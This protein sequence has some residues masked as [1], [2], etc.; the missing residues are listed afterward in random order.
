[1]IEAQRDELT[2]QIGTIISEAEAVRYSIE[3]WELIVNQIEGDRA[4]CHFGA[5]WISSRRVEDDPLIQ[6]MY[7]AANDLTDEAQKALA[8]ETAEGW[9][10]E[11]RYWAADE[12][13]EQPVVIM[14]EGRDLAL[15]YPYVMDGVE[16]LIPLQEFVS[17]N[18]TEDAQARYRDGIGIIQEAVGIVPLNVPEANTP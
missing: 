14:R 18:W 4:D 9:V 15:Y 11:L 5:N 8:L 17:E 6:G 1:M 12:Y 7:Q 3:D 10:E 16:T 2:E 13:V